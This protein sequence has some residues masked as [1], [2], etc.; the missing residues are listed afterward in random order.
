MHEVSLGVRKSIVELANGTEEPGE[1]Q[2]TGSHELD[3]TE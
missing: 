1:L 3:T 2:S